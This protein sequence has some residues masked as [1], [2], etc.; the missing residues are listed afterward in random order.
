LSGATAGSRQAGSS[1]SSWYG[2]VVLPAEAKTDNA[3]DVVHDGGD[4]AAHLARVRVRED[5][6]VAAG[7]IESHAGRA[8]LVAVGDHPSDGHGITLV[9]VGHERYAVGGA[10]A[11]LDLHQGAF[12][13][14][15][16][17]HRNVVDNLH[18]LLL[19]L[20]SSVFYTNPQA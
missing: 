6:L 7:D 17:P 8:D 2:L 1:N 10:R 16:A 14:G 4:I 20:T 11:I 5:G 19:L 9:V 13:D 12:V 15:R 3:E 18:G